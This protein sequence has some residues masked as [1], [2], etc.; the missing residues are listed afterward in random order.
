LQWSIVEQKKF[1][2]TGKLYFENQH[3]KFYFTLDD[4]VRERHPDVILF[5]GVIQ[6]LENPYKILTDTLSKGFNQIIFDRT[7]FLMNGGIDQLT[8]Q[9]VPPS[10]EI[11]Y[12]AWFF[13][14]D[15]FLEFFSSEYELVADF[16]SFDQIS[17][18]DI[19]AQSKGFIFQK[20]K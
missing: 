12:P 3:L 20:K 14:L 7:P 13:N 2:E 1:V 16:E 15:K 8:L 6:Y 17:K 10:F 11:S 18:L 9:R 5:S 4:C 19:A